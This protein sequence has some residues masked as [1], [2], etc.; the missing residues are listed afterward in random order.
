MLAAALAPASAPKPTPSKAPCAGITPPQRLTTAPVNL[1]PSYTA[2]RVGGVVV[3][4][5]VI[6]ADGTV[7]DVRLVRT[8]LAGLAPFGQKSVQDS[9]FW[10]AR[11]TA[12][13]RPCACACRRSLGTLT[14]ARVEPEYDTV[15]AHVP[16]GQ[17]REAVWQ[18][19]GSV[20]KLALEIHL[21]TDPQAGAEVVARAPDGKERVLHRIPASPTPVD[22]RRDRLHGKVLRVG[23]RLS[24]S[25]SEPRERRWLPRPS[26]SPTTTRGRSSTPANRSSR[27]RPKTSWAGAPGPGPHAIPR[28]PVRHQSRTPAPSVSTGPGDGNRRNCRSGGAR[29][30]RKSRTSL[31]GVSRSVKSGR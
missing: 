2:T 6:G 26:R 13:R 17:S 12:I 1:P 5:A 10:A 25:S 11:S 29:A 7:S 8:R 20:E 23:R 4:E 18:L 9:R 14:R 15:W 31:K 30:G 28:L 3:D 24:P 22:L 21:G 27:G 19:A 16:G